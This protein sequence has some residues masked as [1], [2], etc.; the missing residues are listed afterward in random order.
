MVQ[1][2]DSC[3]LP[4]YAY[5]VHLLFVKKKGGWNDSQNN[6]SNGQK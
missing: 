1:V 4:H 2:Q 5:T 6:S 3:L